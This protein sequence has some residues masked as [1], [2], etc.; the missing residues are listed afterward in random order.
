MITLTTPFAGKRHCFDA[1]YDGVVNLDHPK[2]DFH[3]IWY[4]NSCDADFHAMLQEKIKVFPSHEIVIDITPPL[5]IENTPDYCRVSERC[6]EVYC[7]LAELVPAD[8]E[9]MFN[10]EDDVWVPPDSLSKMLA[11]FRLDEKIGTVIG[12]Q[13]C[14]RFSKA[15][16]I[17]PIPNAWTFEIDYRFPEGDVCKEKTA[18]RTF[19]EDKPFGVEIIGSG[20]L[21]CWLTKTHLVKELGFM[22]DKDG[23][24]A[25]DTVWGYRLREHGYYFV[26]DYSIRCRH[27]YRIEGEVGYL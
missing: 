13:Y 17:R 27:Y 10:V 7:N 25:N 6:H 11:I 8:N 20:H 3:V 15:K 12:Q 18:K 19:I 22:M 26:I 21:G 2:D 1:Y 24:R 16:N 23:L 4:D 14:R 5:V 9:F